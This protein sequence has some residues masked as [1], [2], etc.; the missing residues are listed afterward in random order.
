MARRGLMPHNRFTDRF[1]S[2]VVSIGELESYFATRGEEAFIDEAE[3]VEARFFLGDPAV[4]R[5]FNERVWRAVTTK[6]RVAFIKDLLGELRARRARPP[7]GL[8]IKLGPGGLREIH[9]MWLAIRVHAN[10]PGPLVPALL[11]LAENAFPSVRHDLRYLM[12]AND[13]LRAARDLYRLAVVF[14]DQMEPERLVRIALDLEPLRRAGVREPYRE[15]LEQLM[16]EVAERIDRVAS[17]LEASLEI[18]G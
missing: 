17:A 4:A 8:N 3:V 11:Q 5:A 7:L 6:N 15:R 12:A 9:L 14:D 13:E 10:L 18:L 16:R 1:N 2:Y